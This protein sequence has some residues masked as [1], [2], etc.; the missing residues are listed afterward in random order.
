MSSII[1]PASSQKVAAILRQS[2]QRIAVFEATTAGLIAASLVAQPG[3][4]G[5]FVSSS[6]VYSGRGAKQLLPVQVL[7]DSGLMDREQNYQSAEPYI[8]SKLRFCSHVATAMR[9]HVK[10][11]WILVENGT[12]GPE[13][14]VPQV[15]AGFTAV[16]VSG[17]DGACVVRVFKTQ[18]RDRVANMQAF[19]DFA[20]D[21]LLECMA[22]P[23][24]KL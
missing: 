11:D 5:F 4:S 12:S 19:T 18:S 15:E 10:A 6:V 1:L 9:E 24:A 23:P 20:M 14:F 22:A 7:R 2:K 17:P 13:F 3:A 16:A 8:A 21:L